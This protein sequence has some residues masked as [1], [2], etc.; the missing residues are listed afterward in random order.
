MGLSRQLQQTRREL[1][2]PREEGFSGYPVWFR[3]E[4]LAKWYAGE[5]TEVSLASL[6]CW[7]ERRSPHHQTGTPARTAIVGVDMI[8]LDLPHHTFRL[9]NG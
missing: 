7:E 6:Y 5:A 8:H 1:P 4:Q 2:H 9:H 3:D